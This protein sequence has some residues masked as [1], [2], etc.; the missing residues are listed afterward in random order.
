MAALVGAD[1]LIAAGGLD[2]VQQ[3]SLA[4]IV[5]D[6]D[7]IGALRRYTRDDPIDEAHAL[8]DDIRAV[9]IGGH[10]LG[11]KSTRRFGRTEVWRPAGVPARHASRSSGTSRW[12]RP[13]S[14]GRRRCLPATSR[15]RCPTTSTVTS[16]R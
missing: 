4:K 14:S 3:S 5:L 1:S 7:Q 2:G 11:R 8:I 16:T 6:C 9:G 15:R 10:F 12:S 13:P